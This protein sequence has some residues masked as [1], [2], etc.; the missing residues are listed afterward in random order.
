METYYDWLYVV[1]Q[2]VRERTG[3]FGVDDL[4][5]APTRTFYREGMDPEDAA[6]EII[7]NDG[8]FA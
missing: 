7:L 4:V 2:I 6:D 8:T 3:G 1:D 5:D